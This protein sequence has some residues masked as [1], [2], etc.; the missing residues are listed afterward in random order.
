MTRV[1][2]GANVTR[3][4]GGAEPSPGAS[5]LSR[6]IRSRRAPLALLPALVAVLA[7][8]ATASPISSPSAE[9]DPVAVG[10]CTGVAVVVDFGVLDEPSISACVTPGAATDVLAVAGVSTE[11]TADY[12]DQV[13][14][15]V[16]GRPAPDEQVEVPGVDPFVEECV[17]MPSAN[18]YWALWVRSAAD[19]DWEYATEGVATLQLGAGESVGLVYTAGTDQSPPKG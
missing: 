16:A 7:G 19:A 4:R 11:G 1:E 9:P 15:R 6:V 17:S 2:T 3:R 12:G 14:C 8:C 18:A 13:V 5:R 10:A